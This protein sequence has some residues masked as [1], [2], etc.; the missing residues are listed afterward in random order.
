VPA[1][2][3]TSKTYFEQVPLEMVNK[4]LEEQ[5]RMSHSTVGEGDETAMTAG[6][7]E[8]PE[9]QAPLQELILEFDCEKFYKKQQIVHAALLERLQQVS[10]ENGPCRE[11]AAL[12]SAL[13]ILRII[14]RDRLGSTDSH[15]GRGTNRVEN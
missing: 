10:V 11:L 6:G 4:L 1:P 5:S 7:L 3:E 14:S 12:N 2:V 15:L 8:L 9:W 13:T